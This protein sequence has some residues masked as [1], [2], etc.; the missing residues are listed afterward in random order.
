MILLS[1]SKSNLNLTETLEALASTLTPSFAAS[2][3]HGIEKENLR[4]KANSELAQTPHPLS[5]GKALTNPT[6]TLDFSDALIE[7]ITP[8]LL[9]YDKLNRYLLTLNRFI[10]DKLSSTSLELPGTPEPTESIWP[11]SMPPEINDQLE[12][13]IA[14]F[15]Q[16]NVAQ[17]KHIYRLGL[18]HRYGRVM[19]AIAG[20]HY[21]VSY[22]DSLFE[23]LQ[24]LWQKQAMP[25]GK[26]RSYAYMK[27]IRNFYR[28]AWLLPYL[29][30]AS[31]VCANTSVGNKVDYLQ[32]LDA[33]HQIAPWGTSLRMSDLGYQNNAQD[34][35]AI[36]LNSVTAYS[37]SLYAA[38]QTHSHEFA[39]IDVK[40]NGVY[41]QLNQNILQIENEYYSF[42]RPKAKPVSGQPPSISLCRHG[43]DYIEV[44]LLDLNPLLTLGIDRNTEMF[45]D[46]FLLFC[47]LTDDYHAD[48]G[49]IDLAR[50]NFQIVATRGRE[51]DLTLANHCKFKEQAQAVL[52]SLQPL[53]DLLG[54]DYQAALDVQD[55]KVANP[56]LT[57]S[58]QL[59]KHFEASKLSYTDFCKQQME[60]STAAI[61]QAD[62]EA[63][64]YQQLEDDIES[65]IEQ[66][67]QEEQQP[68]DF[69]TFLKNY[70]TKQHRCK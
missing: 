13:S 2:I 62:I 5:L 25:F 31:P 35:L 7:M 20:I 19:Q 8:P 56:E 66:W 34:G 65:S 44:R 49:N 23:Q 54:E 39:G 29:F 12:V 33:D 24:T 21:N 70:M 63:D 52:L 1:Q 10:I 41:Q 11:F 69:D 68:Q 16:S 50:K 55:E 22:P 59:I 18:W 47:M 53:A 48:Q 40:K 4:V 36:D 28:Y 60:Q 27:L 57:P 58:A 45:V 32:A 61:L 67:Q 9:G 15:G 38:T 46:M 6:V 17:M 51:P 30:G 26:F 37:R 64:V 3:T 14:E 42:I 43:I